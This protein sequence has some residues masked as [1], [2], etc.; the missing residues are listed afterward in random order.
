MP[1]QKRKR[2]SGGSDSSKEGVLASVPL[3]EHRPA[4]NNSQRVILG[5]AALRKLSFHLNVADRCLEIEEEHDI[6]DD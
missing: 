5:A 4:S 3:Y 6:V 1:D 2:E